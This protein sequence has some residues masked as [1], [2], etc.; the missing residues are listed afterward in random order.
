MSTINIVGLGPGDP[1]LITRKAW[2]LLTGAPE[3]RVRTL[4]H[5][6]VPVLARHTQIKSYD[7][8]YEQHHDFDS[9]YAAIAGDIVARAERGQD[10]VYAVPGDPGV[11][12]A[13]TQA[14]RRLASDRS[15]S[16]AVHPGVSFIEPTFA[17]LGEDPIRGV[18]FVD[19]T[20]LAHAHHPP[21]SPQHGLL[22]A[23]LYSRYLASDVKLTLMNAY[24]DEHPVTLVSGA[25]T[26]DLRLKTLPLYELDRHDVFGDMTT[27]W[28][29]PL[30]RPGGYDALQEVIAHLRAPD[31]CPWDREQTHE[32]L[33]P[34]LL[35]E[36]YEVLEA[37]DRDDAAALAEELGDLLIQVALH[38]QIATEE[39]AFKLPDVIGHVVEK[40]IR[41]HPHVFADVQVADAEEVTR[42]WEAIKEQERQQARTE[43]ET[44]RA[45]LLDGIPRAL[46]ALALAQSYVERLHRVG[47][48]LPA[49]HPLDEREL[50][51]RLLALVEEAQ[52][53]G[54]NAEAALRQTCA[55]LR[56]RLRAVE[57]AA[58]EASLL[59]LER[60]R[61]RELWLAHPLWS[62]SPSAQPDS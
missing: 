30:A 59:D 11:A 27:L 53:A 43:G 36:T 49:A 22:V 21:G 57:A 7:Y 45:T 32:S 14:I 19:A 58:P 3:V 52:A 34:Y 25:G 29:P 2:A 12:E 17:A 24:P 38:V 46:P 39:G 55:A 44:T 60:S 4:H 37:L 51:Q 1:E 16:C 18:E 42:N 40:L 8:L 50:G 26:P 61:Q 62:D 56:R 20:T 13:T 10:V 47:Y 23:Q 28:V 9:V 41:R 54:L 33:R 6:A 5:P 48:P 35:E 31:G 15:I